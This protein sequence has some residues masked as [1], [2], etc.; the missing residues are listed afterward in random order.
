MLACCRDD[1]IALVGGAGLVPL[2]VR[3]QTPGSRLRFSPDGR[4][5]LVFHEGQFVVVDSRGRVARRFRESDEPLPADSPPSDMAFSPEADVVVTAWD[6]DEDR[7]IRLWETSSGR[8]L[9]RF[10]VPGRGP[11]LPTFLPGS[12]ALVMACQRELKRFPLLGHDL[13]RITAV[14][15]YPVRA[16]AVHGANLATIAEEP[17]EPDGRQ[18]GQAILWRDGLR[19]AMLPFE[20]VRDS[21]TSP[22]AAFIA[23]GKQLLFSP[24]APRL[25]MWDLEGTGEQSV[26][27]ASMR[28]FVVGPDGK[29]VWTLAGGSM[30]SWDLP[31]FR[32]A[33][34]W[35]K[36]STEG[37][38]TLYSLAA[39]RERV[40][41]GGR[42][43][44]V[45]LLR[46][47]DGQPERSWAGPGGPVS[48]AALLA[49][50]S[51]G[52]V[53]TRDGRLHVHDLSGDGKLLDASAHD[54]AVEALAFAPSGLLAS[55]SRDRSVKLWRRDG[56][57]YELLLSL[58][59]FPRA[60]RDL[61]FDEEGRRLFI[62][63]EYGAGVRVWDLER[64]RAE[65]E[66]LGIA[67]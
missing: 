59:G 9:T 40:L 28:D 33:T 11:I 25:H 21:I 54:D 50:E 62:L 67:W 36:I 31:S 27:V 66:A 47:V 45:H 6:N 37:L 64:L 57:R 8:L 29:R 52:A 14:Q 51:L 2:P 34:A 65:C 5:L 20:T 10:V 48:A 35:E 7:T 30:Q 32:P 58:R 16:F 60:V 42:D 44:R 15:T 12:R 3:V 4:T 49:D 39:G 18:R 43:G 19:R 46:A 13:A 1:G 56:N 41:A 23:G 17:V 22:R 55:G 26:T 63:L 38:A 53:G 61:R 24:T